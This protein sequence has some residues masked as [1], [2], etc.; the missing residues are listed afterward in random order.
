MKT[1]HEFAIQHAK[2]QS[3]LWYEMNDNCIFVLKVPQQKDA[4]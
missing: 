2:Q 4:R 1:S 3:L